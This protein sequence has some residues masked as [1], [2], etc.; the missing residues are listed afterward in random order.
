MVYGEY[1]PRGRSSLA[2]QIAAMPV[3]V[4]RT[5]GVDDALLV[6][7]DTMVTLAHIVVDESAVPM[8]D[9]LAASGPELAFLD[10]DTDWVIARLNQLS[11]TSITKVAKR[12]KNADG[13]EILNRLFG[14]ATYRVVGA[15]F[16][17]DLR[18][19]LTAVR[20]LARFVRPWAVAFDDM[21]AQLDEKERVDVGLKSPLT[22]KMLGLLLEVDQMLDFALVGER[23]RLP[24]KDKVAP[25]SAAE[26]QDAED[27][28]RRTLQ[29][30][31]DENLEKLSTTF[32]RKIK[33]AR[34]ALE[35]S[36]DGI[37]QAANSLIELI[38]R[39]ARAAFTPDEVLAWLSANNL[40]VEEFIYVERA[41]VR[42]NKR[43]QILCLSWGGMP[44]VE[45]PESLRLER[46]VAFTLLN[47]RQR[48][49]KLKHAEED[50]EEER[51]LLENLLSVIEGAMVMMVR[52]FWLR[53]DAEH[54]QVLREQLAS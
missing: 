11:D 28:L 48:L 12:L 23:L 10:Q 1:H 39:F 18:V 53:V 50:T 35:H 32:A 44:V 9:R 38:D 54:M 25:V 22:T 20:K 36:A 17:E 21:Y 14:T 47:V 52:A 4:R 51:T 19:V 46:F 15:A 7:L 49:Q 29:A 3:S 33:G 40:L 16:D 27:L 8:I 41:Q 42:P 5:L 6:L 13:N 37:S 30:S 43:A 34:D 2:K 45:Q 26:I 24:T 31:A